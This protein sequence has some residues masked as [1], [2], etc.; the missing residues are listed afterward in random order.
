VLFA[1][2]VSWGY[3]TLFEVLWKGQTP[4]KRVAG[5]RVIKETGRPIDIPSAILRNLLR[6]VDFLPAMY[7]IGVTCMVL[8]RHS[9]RLGDFVAGTIVVHDR[10][11][12][13]LATASH[14][15]SPRDPAT[16]APAMATSVR[17]SDR[18]VMLIETYLGRRMELD[19]STEDAAARQIAQLI[20]TRTGLAPAP[21][22]NVNEFLEAIA[23]HGRDQ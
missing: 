21:G 12:V 19:N 10:S 17:I 23:R 6:A 11:A 2:A 9:R 8:N 7:G 22:Q 16:L 1:F 13:R 20:K 3:F 4:G 5:I 18:E 14:A 15:W